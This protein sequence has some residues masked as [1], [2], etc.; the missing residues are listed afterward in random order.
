[1]TG[2]PWKGVAWDI[3]GTLIDSEPLHHQAL[4]AACRVSGLDIT[5]LDDRVFAG[6]QTRDVWCRLRKDWL[7]LPACAPFCRWIN[8]YYVAGAVGLHP[9][10]GAV[11]TIRALAAQGVVQV[12]ASNSDR[13]VVDANLRQLAVG[14]A[15]CASV[16]GDEVRAGKPDPAIYRRAA[17]LAGLAPHD[18]LAV[19][20]SLTGL[21]AARAAGM[22]VVLC[23]PDAPHPAADYHIE[24]LSEL[25][26]LRRTCR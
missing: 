6:L 15:I 13:V 10:P 23:G 1:M 20:D 25:P 3:D 26:D 24:A 5:H 22:M 7:S 19:E 17:D 2:F 9:M 18:M 4:I 16:A 11:S 14:G 21:Q 8:R 12:C